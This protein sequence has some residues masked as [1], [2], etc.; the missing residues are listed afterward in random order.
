MKP[1]GV[2]AGGGAFLG[3]VLLFHD[4]KYIRWSVFSINNAFMSLLLMFFD[5]A[6]IRIVC[7][8]TPWKMARLN[9]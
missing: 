1:S 4:L 2:A 5:L 3:I 8:N 6:A 7:D 9:C